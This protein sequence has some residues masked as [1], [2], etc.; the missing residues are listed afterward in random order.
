[1]S[2]GQIVQCGPKILGYG[3]GPWAWWGGTQAFLDGGGQASMGGDKGP[4]G[5]G[6]PPSPPMS[7]NPGSLLNHLLQ[8]DKTEKILLYGFLK[9]KSVLIAYL[10]NINNFKYDCIICDYIFA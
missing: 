10:I 6:P 7:A 5:G 8:T 2:E 1:M 4:M 9:I 3:G